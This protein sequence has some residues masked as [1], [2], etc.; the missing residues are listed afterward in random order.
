MKTEITNAVIEVA[1][2][3]ENTPVDN[4][5]IVLS[6]GVVLKA[7]AVSTLVITDLTRRLTK[8]TVPTVY[9]KDIGRDE[10]NPFSPEYVGKMEKWEA[11]V[12]SGMIDTFILLGTELVSIPKGMPGADGKEWREDMELLGIEISSSKKHS[13]LLWI[14]YVAAP[15]QNDIS[16]IITAVSRLSGVIEEDVDEAVDTFPGDAERGEDTVA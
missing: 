9:N 14:K 8:P 15:S 13:Y 10:E 2:Q 16:E 5:S 4:A 6:T 12:S 1:E 3:I 7:R 11:D